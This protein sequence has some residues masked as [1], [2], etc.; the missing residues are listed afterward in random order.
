MLRKKTHLYFIVAQFADRVTA[1]TLQPVRDQLKNQG[2]KRIWIVQHIHCWPVIAAFRARKTNLGRI[3]LIVAESSSRNTT[4]LATF[5]ANNVTRLW[6][7]IALRQLSW[8]SALTSLTR[9]Q[10]DYF[11][12]ALPNVWMSLSVDDVASA[13]RSMRTL[14]GGWPS[15][16]PASHKQINMQRWL[17]TNF[18]TEGLSIA[19]VFTWKLPVRD[20]HMFFSITRCR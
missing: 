4:V 11:A 5:K 7:E 20:N 16:A 15:T 2:Y 1:I 18:N 13:L 10:S 8:S 6:R 17:M 3:S 9:A 14:G 19:V 12:H